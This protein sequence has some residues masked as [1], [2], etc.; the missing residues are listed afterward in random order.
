MTRMSEVKIRSGTG[1]NIM[2]GALSSCGAAHS[3]PNEAVDG[4]R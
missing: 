4:S 1:I 3:S 2:S